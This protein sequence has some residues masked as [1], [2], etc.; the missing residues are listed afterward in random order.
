[1]QGTSLRS[2]LVVALIAGGAACARDA[3]PVVP[4]SALGPVPR[5][6]TAAPEP[7]AARPPEPETLA[8]AEIVPQ[9]DPAVARTGDRAATALV[10]P[11]AP[12]PVPVREVVAVMAPTKGNKARGTVRFRDSGEG[13]LDVR[14]EIVGL[15]RGPHAF[16]VHVFGDCSSPDATSAGDHFHFEGS[17]MDHSVPI[18]TGDLGELLSDGRRTTIHEGR[19]PDATLQ[20]AFSI[21][22]RAVVIHERGNNPAITPDGGAG[23]RISCGVIG[24][25]S[26]A[27]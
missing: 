19:I 23:K 15:P 25:A 7:P 13:G 22:G 2:S 5:A 26:T 4:S 17:S 8:P 9:I 10:D 21:V 24:V 18:I 6:A 12:E 3:A 20:G 16:H 1:M 14:A 11:G 27:P